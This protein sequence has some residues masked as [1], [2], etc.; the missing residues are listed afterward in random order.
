MYAVVAWNHRHLYKNM[1][2]R[3]L[4]DLPGRAIGW[5]HERRRERS[6]RLFVIAMDGCGAKFAQELAFRIRQQRIAIGSRV[7]VKSAKVTVDD[8]VPV[9]TTPVAYH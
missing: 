1:I 6:D 2:I 3:F 5:P 8:L 4:H 7:I 9:S